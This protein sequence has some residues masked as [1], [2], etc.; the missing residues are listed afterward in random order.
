MTLDRD[1]ATVTTFKAICEGLNKAGCDH[2]E[3]LDLSDVNRY[4]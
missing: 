2:V 4:C 3:P 1:F